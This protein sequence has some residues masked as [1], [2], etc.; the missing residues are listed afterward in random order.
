MFCTLRAHESLRP[1]FKLE[2]KYHCNFQ[3]LYSIPGVFRSTFHSFHPFLP[4]SRLLPSCLLRSRRLTMI[5]P[6]KS[7]STSLST[8]LQTFGSTM[9]VR[10][11]LEGPVWHALTRCVR[12][13]VMTPQQSRPPAGA[14]IRARI[15]F[16]RVT[17]PQ[18]SACSS[19]I[20]CRIPFRTSVE[21][22]QEL[23]RIYRSVQCVASPPGYHTC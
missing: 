23:R 16:D 12:N 1:R 10:T 14:L 9:V 20:V 2:L 17:V 22:F 3:P 11:A 8:P 13:Q 6:T 15:P 5:T 19:H 7:M 21:T 4:L 18:R